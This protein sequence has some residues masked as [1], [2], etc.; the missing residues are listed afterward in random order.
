[1]SKEVVNVVIVG[2][3][4]VGKSTIFNKL[5]KQKKSITE[6]RSGVT[7]DRVI[8]KVDTKSGYF[9][10]TDTAG[11]EKSVEENLSQ[12]TNRQIDV[13]LESA[14]LAL[15]VVDVSSGLVM[16]DEQMAKKL[17]KLKVPAILVANKLDKVSKER[18]KIFDFYSLGLKNIVEVSAEHNLNLD[19]LLEN[20]ADTL[21]LKKSEKEDRKSDLKL[22]IIGRPNVGKSSLLNAI[23]DEDRAIVSNLAGT[24]RDSVEGEMRYKGKIISIVDTAGIR[25]KAKVTDTVE[26][27]SVIK[28]VS[29]I[30]EADV[31]ILVLDS[32]EGIRE[33]DKKILG[34]A[35]NRY[36]PL[37]ICAN[38][39]DK[40]REMPKEK[41]RENT[42]DDLQFL[43]PTIIFTSA[44]KKI[45]IN[46]LLNKCIELNEKSQ[47]KFG[48]GALN[49]LLREIVDS[50]PPANKKGKRPRLNYITQTAT[51]P[52][53]FSIFCS[54]PDLIHF[55]YERYIKNNISKALDLKDIRVK[56]KYLRDRD[57]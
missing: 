40:M 18:E 21:N 22:A 17:R 46:K 8:T 47:L 36:K 45:G 14:N 24:T 11:L 57:N 2:R 43:S 35:F 49:K 10:L 31:T 19:K 38:K 44:L 16:E 37:I 55:S 30:Q 29:S 32:N 4:N 39:V 50:N 41:F 52:P 7:R 26:Y 5:S 3:P 51:R 6:K 25:K 20:I 48:T 1:M 12:E 33:Q 42:S 28:A 9:F 54:N 56:I 53:T 13:A 23:L 27:Y 15:L 34:L